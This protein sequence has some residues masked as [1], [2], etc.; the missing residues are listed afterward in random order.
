[1]QTA[2]SNTVALCMDGKMMR[3]KLVQVLERG[4]E[5]ATQIRRQIDHQDDHD[6]H[7]SRQLDAYSLDV[8]TSFATALSMIHYNFPSFNDDHDH[9][10]PKRPNPTLKSQVF[11]EWEAPNTPRNARGSYKRR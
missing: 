10:A 6:H 4:K 9:Q 3:E 11:E 7:D 2:G 1:M 8:L 5:S